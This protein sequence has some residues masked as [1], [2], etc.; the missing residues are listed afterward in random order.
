[1]NIK[2]LIWELSGPRP[3]RRVTGS[4][5]LGYWHP[6]TMFRD[7]S[8]LT[9]SHP[10]LVLLV[11]VSLAAPCT[12]RP[13]AQSTRLLPHVRAKYNLL[14]TSDQRK[15]SLDII[16][17]RGGFRLKLDGSP[18]SSPLHGVSPPPGGFRAMHTNPQHDACRA[19]DATQTHAV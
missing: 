15:P 13:E 1:M 11:L 18:D 8:S 4:A 19:A 12:P 5:N 14:V 10:V 16:I 17:L 2:G 7:I 6:S 9:D 3:S